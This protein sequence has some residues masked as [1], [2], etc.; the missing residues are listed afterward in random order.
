[1]GWYYLHDCTK[2]SNKMIVVIAEWQNVGKLG[3]IKQFCIIM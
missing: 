3:R 1:M 2:K